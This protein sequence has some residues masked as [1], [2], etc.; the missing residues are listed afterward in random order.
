MHAGHGSAKQLASVKDLLYVGKPC[1]LISKLGRGE[2][3]LVC[4]SLG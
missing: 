1:A 3:F 4:S 2:W